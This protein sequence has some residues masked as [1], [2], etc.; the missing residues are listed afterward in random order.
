MRETA[1]PT[2]LTGPGDYEAAA[3]YDAFVLLARSSTPR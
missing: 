2:D 1:A 3:A